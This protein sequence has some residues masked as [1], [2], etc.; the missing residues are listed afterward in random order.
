MSSGTRVESP[1]T[2]RAMMSEWLRSRTRSWASGS[3]TVRRWREQRYQQFMRLCDV[4]PEEAILDV[5]AG[6]GAALERFND[7]NPIVA[8]DLEP[9]NTGW[10][11]QS[12]VMVEVGDATSLPFPD[13]SFPVAFSNSVIEHIPVER[14]ETFAREIRRVSVRY[15]VQTPNRYFPIE[16]HYQFPFFQFLPRQVQ[17]WLKRSLHAGLARP[18]HLGGHSLAL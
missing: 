10:L 1:R 4:K 3:S 18:R 13:G 2:S 14:R 15:F 17:R 6:G 11:S 16:P 7:T 8:L 9:R 12:N 5:G